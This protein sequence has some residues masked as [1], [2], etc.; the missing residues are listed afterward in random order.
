MVIPKLVEKLRRP[1]CLLA[2][3]VPVEIEPPL[4]RGRDQFVGFPLADRLRGSPKIGPAL[5]EFNKGLRMEPLRFGGIARTEAPLFL[6]LAK[7][8]TQIVGVSTALLK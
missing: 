2:R 6:L 4:I 8:W 7:D 3:I 1:D 5:F